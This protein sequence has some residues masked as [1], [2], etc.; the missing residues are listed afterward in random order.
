MRSFITSSASVLDKRVFSLKV[1][2]YDTSTLSMITPCLYINVLLF[3]HCLSWFAVMWF[4][5]HY[6]GIYSTTINQFTSFQGFNLHAAEKSCGSGDG[7]WKIS[8]PLHDF[9]SENLNKSQKEAIDVIKS[10]L[11]IYFP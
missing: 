8:G 10:D 1:S 9:F 5:N 7:P 4:I 11:V 6:S 2:C 3:I